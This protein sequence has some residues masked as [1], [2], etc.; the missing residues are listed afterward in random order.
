MTIRGFLF[1]ALACLFAACAPQSTP[2]PSPSPA[3]K[4]PLVSRTPA[5]PV[6]NT[7]IQAESYIVIDTLT[8]KILAEKNARTPRAVASTQKLLTALCVYRAGSLEDPVTIELT[9]TQVEPSK[10]YVAPGETYTRRTLV[11]ALLVRSG[12]DIAKAL[13]RDV[14]GSE[15]EFVAYMNRTAASLGMTSSFFRNPHGLTEPGQYSTALDL[16]M[17]AR[18]VTK[19]PFY[20]Q[21]MRTKEYTFEYPDGRTKTLENTN[22]VLK[23]LPYCTGMKTGYTKAS[24]RCLISSGVL[25]GKAVI[26]V[27]L[28]STSSEIWNDS[29]K[30]LKG[31]LE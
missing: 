21:C 15:A 11:K 23:R 10:I 26:A 19:I 12:N 18:E 31:H 25:N 5:A 16:A 29:V 7:A 2:K 13:A 22:K 3:R 9:D 1:P 17:L 28:G 24:G 14:S 6:R 4:E 20:R 30:L 27:A 8:G